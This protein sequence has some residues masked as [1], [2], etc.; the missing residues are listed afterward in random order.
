MLKFSL[1]ENFYF[2]TKKDYVVETIRT[3]ILV[4]DILPGTRITEQQIKD[5]LKISSSPIREA[6]QQLEAEGLR[7]GILMNQ[8]TE[9]DSKGC[10]GAYSSR[11]SSRERPFKFPLKN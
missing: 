3:S 4:G 10:W 9:M 5:L 2:G 7:P 1:L 6:L 11:L 8:G